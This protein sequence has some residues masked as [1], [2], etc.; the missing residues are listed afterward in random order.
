MLFT[1][2]TR[3]R[4]HALTSDGVSALSLPATLKI[5]AYEKSMSVMSFQIGWVDDGF[6]F[7]SGQTIPLWRRRFVGFYDRL[8]LK[9]GKLST[10]GKWGPR[11]RANAIPALGNVQHQRKKISNNIQRCMQ[12]SR[13]NS[14]FWSSTRHWPEFPGRNPAKH[15]HTVLCETGWLLLNIYTQW[16]N[17]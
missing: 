13:L 4:S 8:C 9:T 5:L 7:I 12:S 2:L 10:F 1:P 15:T 6:T 17:I 3:R 14:N 16:E 11:I